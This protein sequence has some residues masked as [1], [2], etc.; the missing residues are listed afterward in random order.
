MQK[1][2]IPC[3]K[4][5][6]F[7]KLCGTNKRTLFHYDEIGLF[8]PAYTDEKGYRYYSE[9]QCDVFFTIT[10]LKELGMP[11]KEIRK[12]I[13][14]QN[15]SAV[16]GLLLTQQKKVAAEL[17]HLHRIQTVIN[18]KLDLIRQAEEF[19]GLH[20]LSGIRLEEQGRDE[21]LVLSDPIFSDDHDQIFSCL[22]RHIGDCNSSR[23]NCGHPYGAMLPVPAL[24]DGGH[25]TYAYFFTKVTLP[26]CRIP[27]HLETHVKNKGRYA[28]VYLR[29]DY[30]QS[31]RALDL[32]MAYL[33][34]HGLIPGE[35]VYKEAVLDEFSA[36]EE[37][38]L[39]RIS[40]RLLQA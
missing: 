23:L 7:A 15:P 33:D 30:Y 34:E 27:E 4:T 3:I 11:L 18:T 13:S 12:F 8:S 16:E 17:E 39:T 5:G 9:N 40:V 32:L 19:R 28:A 25:E 35:Y 26:C 38:Y 20:D 1:F 37:D 14:N 2:N 36:K 22:C 24:R 6:D 21:L 31:D 10:C 29:G